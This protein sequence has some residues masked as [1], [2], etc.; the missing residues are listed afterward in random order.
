[1]TLVDAS[2]N[3]QPITSKPELGVVNNNAVVFVGTGRYLGT[4]DLSDTSQQSFYAIKDDL[5]ANTLGNP[6]STGNFVQQTETTINCPTGAAASLC[7]V[8][9]KV[10]SSTNN[11]VNFAVNNG[12]FI[13]FPTAGERA[14]TDPTL[15]L[16]TLAFNTNIPNSSACTVGGL[17]NRY[18]VD[19]RTGGAVSTAVVGGTTGI[20]A[21]RLGNALATRP[22]LVR[23]PNNTIVELTRMSDGTTVTNQVPI[24]SGA[25]TI[26]RISWRELITD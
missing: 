16:G 7:S 10:R 22:V 9:Q 21:A 3:P 19:Y 13:D 18:F 23:L 8:G 17:S 15:A 20:V 6:R 26:R 14:N 5:S 12:W 11:P 4:P 24:G 25:G 2:G 1:V